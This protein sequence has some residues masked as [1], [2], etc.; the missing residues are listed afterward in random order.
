MHVSD[1]DEDDTWPVSASI[2]NT[3]SMHALTNL[4]Y[5]QQVRL[6]EFQ[7][8]NALLIER[9]R[10]RLMAKHAELSSKLQADLT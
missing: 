9:E 2:Y 5:E 4:S 7:L 3:S 8:Q 10:M 6:A 1:Y